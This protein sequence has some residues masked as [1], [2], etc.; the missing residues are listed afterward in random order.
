MENLI[1]LGVGAVML[2][3]AFIFGT[4]GQRRHYQ[5]IKSREERLRHILIFNEK[6]PP[7][8]CAGQKYALVCG[9]VVMGGDYFRQV[10]AGLKSIFGGRLT[11]FEAMLDRGR[12]ESI[13]RM[14]EE[15]RRLGANVIFNA[16][17][18]TT[19]LSAKQNGDEGLACA[20]FLVYGTAWRSPDLAKN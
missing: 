16:R 7:T 11:S 5:S 9:S 14:K 18:E 15:A 20:E 19:T 2:I 1:A 8:S 3:V 6:T 17:F 12:R 10:I 13:L 4:L